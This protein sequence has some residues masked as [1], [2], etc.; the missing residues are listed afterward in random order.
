MRYLLRYNESVNKNELYTFLNDFGAL[1]SLNLS[2]A[3]SFSIDDDSKIELKKMLLNIRKPIINGKTYFDI[4][5][6]DGMINNPK[7][8]SALLSQIKSLLEYVYPRIDKYINS[9][10]REVWL[11][12]IVKLKERYIR[13]VT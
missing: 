5:N 7:I 10:R 13:V 8:L 12:K 6:D 9:E 4:I 2:K 3:E 1:I 11:E